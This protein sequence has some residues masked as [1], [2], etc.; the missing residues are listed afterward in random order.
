[1]S[2]A[3]DLLLTLLIVVFFWSMAGAL[4]LWLL[5][6]ALARIERIEHAVDRVE[7]RS[8]QHAI[9]IGVLGLKYQR[10]ENDSD[11]SNDV[12]D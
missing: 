8:H 2:S 7:E 3:N 10:L 6:R 5:S 4:V 12:S 11:E 1:M 9:E